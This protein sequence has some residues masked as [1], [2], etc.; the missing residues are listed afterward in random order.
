MGM[1]M[2]VGVGVL[3]LSRCKLCTE[4]VRPAPSHLPA[5]IAV[6]ASRSPPVF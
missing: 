3:W 6:R 5:G 2:G 4:Q 1:G